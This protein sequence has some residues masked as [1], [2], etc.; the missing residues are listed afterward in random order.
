MLRDWKKGRQKIM[1]A[2]IS[3][4]WGETQDHTTEFSFGFVNRKRFWLEEPTNALLS[5]CCIPSHIRSIFGDFASS[6]DNGN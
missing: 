5:K 2:S 4:L 1:P 6:Y 3:M